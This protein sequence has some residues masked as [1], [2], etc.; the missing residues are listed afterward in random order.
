MEASQEASTGAEGLLHRFLQNPL[1]ATEEIID[2]PILDE[3]GAVPH[4]NFN[5]DR[6]AVQSKQV[7]SVW[8][9]ANPSGDSSSSLHHDNGPFRGWKIGAH[10]AAVAVMQVS[11]DQEINATLIQHWESDRRAPHQVNGVH[12][13]SRRWNEWMVR[14][15]DF[16]LIIRSTANMLPDESDL[17]DRYPSA[18]PRE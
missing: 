10:V 12:W 16:E 2:L 14:H 4:A 13:V 18:F 8:F 9:G 3:G 5:F 11:R 15:Q 1:L 6:G 17:L 7:V